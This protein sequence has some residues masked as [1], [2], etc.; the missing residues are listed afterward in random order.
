MTKRQA[1]FALQDIQAGR[2]THV[3]FGPFV[4][5]HTGQGMRVDG[6]EL[7]QAHTTLGGPKAVLSWLE[8]KGVIT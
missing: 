6:P 1:L 4:V 8:D 3:H 7:R 2:L 5:E